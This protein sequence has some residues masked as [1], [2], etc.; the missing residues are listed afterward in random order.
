MK[1]SVELDCKTGNIFHNFCGEENNKGLAIY[2]GRIVLQ[3]NNNN[4]I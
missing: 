4:N 1:I 2:K 3:N